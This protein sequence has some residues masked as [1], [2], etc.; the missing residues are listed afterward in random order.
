MSRY[1]GRSLCRIGS[2]GD[3]ERRLLELLMGILLEAE[4]SAASDLLILFEDVV[5]EDGLKGVEV[6]IVR[7][8]LASNNEPKETLKFEEGLLRVDDDVD[9]LL[10]T[11]DVELFKG[12][13]MIVKNL[14][15][16]FKLNPGLVLGFVLKNIIMRH[17]DLVKIMNY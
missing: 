6:V 9:W 13:P 11:I 3:R 14:L 1:H 5:L 2:W 17:T 16:E 8:P 15:F 7:R 10:L 4:N 12:I